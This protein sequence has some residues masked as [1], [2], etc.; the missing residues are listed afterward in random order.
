MANRENMQKW[1]DALRSGEFKQGKGH[2]RVNDTYCCLGVACELAL[3]DGVELPVEIHA[4]QCNHAVD[5]KEK[6]SGGMYEYDGGSSVL[7]KQVS[8]WLG[9]GVAHP[10]A[11]DDDGELRGVAELNDLHGMDFNR[12]ADAIEAEYLAKVPA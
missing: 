8:D 11:R 3:R 12:I 1:V 4:A 5:L 9:I 6:H 7:P 2:L 10:L